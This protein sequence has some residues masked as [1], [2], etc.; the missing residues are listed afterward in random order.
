ML[1]PC[2]EKVNRLRAMGIYEDAKKVVARH[3]AALE[4]VFTTSRLKHISAARM[5]LM[6]FIRETFQWSYPA[7]GELFDRDHTTIIAAIQKIKKQRMEKQ[8]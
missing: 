4:D 3:G 1:R 7:L 2:D 6:M 8:T 5:E